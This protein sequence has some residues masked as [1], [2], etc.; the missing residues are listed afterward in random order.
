MREI[1][2]PAAEWF[3]PDILLVSAGYDAHARDPLAQMNVSDE[4]FASIAR[5]TRRIADDF[6]AGH[7]AFTLGGG[8]DLSALTAGV[9]SAVG[10]LA[11]HEPPPL[12][13]APDQIM[14]AVRRVIDRVVQTHAP[15]RA[16]AR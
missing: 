10:A 1:A 5:E 16:A 15:F 11:V 2:R 9:R 6:A 3:A 14:P 7:V 12:P 8:Y 4:G 13:P